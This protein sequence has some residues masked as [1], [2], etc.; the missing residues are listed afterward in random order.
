MPT[1]ERGIVFDGVPRRLGQAEFLIPYLRER[2]HKNMATVFLDVPRDISIKRL[3]QRAEHETRTDDTP[4]AIETRFKYYDE[5]T[6]PLLDYLRRETH[7]FDIDGTPSVDEI[8][9]DI[10]AEL[11]I[12]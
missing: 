9:K 1:T 4:E 8:E 5:E 2:G 7:F 3:L 12:T 6:P 11:G 10:D